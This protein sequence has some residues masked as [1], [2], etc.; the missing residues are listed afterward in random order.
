MFDIASSIEKYLEMLRALDE[1]HKVW[2]DA[3]REAAIAARAKRSIESNADAA[4]TAL[5]RTKKSNFTKRDERHV[6]SVVSKSMDKTLDAVGKVKNFP[7]DAKRS[8]I[9]MRKT[10]LSDLKKRDWRGAIESS[11]GFFEAAHAGMRVV[12]GGK[13]QVE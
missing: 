11:R 13:Y 10:T 5:M 8:M 2:S 3:A 1:V 4:S 7:K 6:V 9:E 12:E